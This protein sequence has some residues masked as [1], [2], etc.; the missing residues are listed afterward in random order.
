MVFAGANSVGEDLAA[1]L[2]KN[3]GPWYKQAHL[4]KLNFCI[5]SLILFSSS[6]GYDGSLMNGLQAL[7]AWQTFMGTPTGAWLG[8][9]NAIYWIG[10]G[11]SYPIAAWVANKWGRKTGVWIGYMFLILGA[12]LQCGANNDIAFV[13]ARLFVGCASAWFGNSVPLLLNEIAYPTQRGIANALFNCGW[14]IG[15]TLA[16][17]ITFGTR[18]MT[19]SWGWRIPSLLQVLI[20]FVALPGFLLCSESPRWLIFVGRSQEARQILATAH[21]GGDL[22]APLINYE[23][24]EIENTIQ[25]EKDAHNSAGYADMIKT[26]GNRRRLFIAISLGVFAQWTGNGVVSYYL[27]LI[28]NSVGVT[29]TSNQLIISACLQMWNL[30]FAVWAAFNVDTLGR[31]KLF[32][33]SATIMF[34]SF[35]LVTALSGS[36]AT[37]GN[38]AT[39][40]ATVAFLFT[41]FAGYDIALTPF[42]VAYPVEIF[43]FALRSRGLTVT[44]VSTIV[45][46]FFNTFVNP[47]ALSAIGWKYYIV[48]VVVT[49]VFGIT[50]YFFYPETRGYSLE[51]IAV[52]FDGDDANVA[53][54]SETS[55]KVHAMAATHIE[56]DHVEKA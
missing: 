7:G 46:I 26:P 42:L 10:T 14:Y 9:I 4:W 24:T 23:I 8:F 53:P 30:I 40:V 3:Q 47:I 27:A 18:D 2:P 35:V 50:V 16:A 6:N 56:E 22:D 44:W 17:W 29:S 39:G 19:S 52:I 38:S 34:I 28:L 43:P 25:F 5:F 54:P 12:G 33:A 51:Q 36:F 55:Q 45:A 31:R 48:F 11:I 49:V 15:G 13:L 21:A 41:Y 37:T 32:L 20:P 1:V